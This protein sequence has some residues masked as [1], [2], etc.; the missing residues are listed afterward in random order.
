MDVWAE[1]SRSVQKM[2]GNGYDFLEVFEQKLEKEKLRKKVTIIKCIWFIRNTF[3]FQDTFSSPTN[4][5]GPA[6][7]SLQE[8]R[9][10]QVCFK[11]QPIAQENYI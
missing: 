4:M 8:F 6:L 3:L 5:M 1:K 7:G 9:Q 2:D 11:S 10:L